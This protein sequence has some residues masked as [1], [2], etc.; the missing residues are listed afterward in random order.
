MLTRTSLHVHRDP[1]RLD[2]EGEWYVINDVLC[3]MW[4][5]ECS[6]VMWVTLSTTQAN[7][8]KPRNKQA[9]RKRNASAMQA[10]CKRNASATQA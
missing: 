10:Q 2:W 9:R 7:S 5:G 8:R 6:S 1:V 4:N 3:V